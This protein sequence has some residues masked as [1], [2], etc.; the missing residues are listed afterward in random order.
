[1]VLDNA[2]NE[3]QVRPLLA[4]GQGCLTL[5]TSRRRLSA[6]SQA[7]HLGVGVFIPDEAQK[8]ISSRTSTTVARSTAY[9]RSRISSL[10]MN[11]SK[12]FAR[13]RACSSGKL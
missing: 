6:L 7:A 4:G 12:P 10:P 1:V 13:H 11:D 3:D 8:P 5:V 9:S 2:A